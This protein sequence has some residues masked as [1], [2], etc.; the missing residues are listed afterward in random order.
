MVYLPVTA[1]GDKG[2]LLAKSLDH[3]STSYAAEIAQQSSW[4]SLW[5]LAL[6]D[7][8][9]GTTGMQNLYRE[10]TRP[11]FASKCHLCLTEV[12]KEK[13]YFDHFIAK[14]SVLLNP[15]EVCKQLASKNVSNLLTKFR[16]RNILNSP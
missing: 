9:I 1:N 14:H 11:V 16:I 4:L 12:N 2:D 3:V 15:K 7:G 5:D 13:P 10:L 6:D 8:T